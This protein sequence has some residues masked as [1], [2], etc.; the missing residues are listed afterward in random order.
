MGHAGDLQSEG[1]RRLLVNAVYWLL[2]MEVPERAKVDFVGEYK[3][4]PIG[5][6]GHKKGVKPSDHRLQDP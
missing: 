1:F 2:G 5:F 4:T 3:P 6:G